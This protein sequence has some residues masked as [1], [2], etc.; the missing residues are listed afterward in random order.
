M[1]K[2]EELNRGTEEMR[3]PSKS[4]GLIFFIEV[5]SYNPLLLKSTIPATPA[6]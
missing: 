1:M 2:F 4:T 5:Q 3:V 6:E